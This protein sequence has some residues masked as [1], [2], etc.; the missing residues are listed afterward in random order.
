ML[1]RELEASLNAVA[2]EASTKRHEF[3]TVEHLLLALTNN[4]EA[5]SVLKQVGADVELLN[6]DVSKYIEDTTP[7]LPESETERSTQTTLGF[8][9]CLLYTS[10]SPRDRYISRM[11]SSA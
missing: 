1:S 5:I 8:Q 4:E 11:P 9:S 10:P 2:Q 7:I 3:V 6:K